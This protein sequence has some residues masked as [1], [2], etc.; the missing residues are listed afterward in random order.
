MT[1]P[2]L[3]LLSLNWNAGP[4]TV[5]WIESLGR[6][7]Y[8]LDRI[9]IL[10]RDNASTDDSADL[11]ADAIRHGGAPPHITF[12]RATTHPGVTS[13]LNE[14]LEMV[15]PDCEIVL[16]VDNDVELAPDC[17]DALVEA[18]QANP[19]AGIAGP[20]VMYA[21][22]QTRLNSGAVYLSWSGA[23]NRIV[24]S[25]SQVECDVILGCVMAFR[26]ELLRRLDYWLRGDFF[27]FAEEPDVCFRSLRAGFSTLYVPQAV[28]FHDTKIASNKHPWLS[29][30]LNIRN[31]IRVHAEYGP[32]A[33]YAWYLTRLLA[34]VVKR[35]LARGDGAE[36]RGYIAGVLGRPVTQALWQRG[37]STHAPQR[38]RS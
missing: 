14:L 31:H 13:A 18:L 7:A 17:L 32:R 29:A 27:F 3:A 20:R 34:G 6:L 4:R 9:E 11:I 30:Y 25:P 16:R 12:V 22:D 36:L 38:S 8:P 19:R 10:I 5:R 33:Q 1:K 23:P 37:I 21:S 24:D 35:S 26:R 15:S 2:K 28:A